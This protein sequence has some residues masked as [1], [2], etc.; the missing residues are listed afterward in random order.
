L[1]AR[2]AVARGNLA[3]AREH[4]QIAIDG[5][6]DDAEAY[7]DLVRLLLAAGDAP[8]AEAVAERI[9][10]RLRGAQERAGDDRTR[11]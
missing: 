8:A 2:V 4:F 3:E 11:W 1:S 5:Q 6:P 10:T 7:H 9:A